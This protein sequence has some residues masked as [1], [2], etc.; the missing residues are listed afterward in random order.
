MRS[1]RLR[2]SSP[3]CIFYLTP[4]MTLYDRQSRVLWKRVR[5]SQWLV[6]GL[7]EKIL[8][9]F[10]YQSGSSLSFVVFD[11]FGW[12][13]ANPLGLKPKSSASESSTCTSGPWTQRGPCLEMIRR[14]SGRLGLGISI[15]WSW[16]ILLSVRVRSV[17]ILSLSHLAEFQVLC[18]SVGVFGSSCTQVMTLGTRQRLDIVYTCLYSSSLV[19]N[20]FIPGADQLQICW[21]LGRSRFLAG[22]R[23]G[24][25]WEGVE[26]KRRMLIFCFPWVLPVISS[27]SGSPEFEFSDLWSFV[28]W[29]FLTLSFYHSQLTS[30]LQNE[31]NR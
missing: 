8:L 20:I 6:E 24:L 17:R 4:D 7:V 9:V 12:N 23:G 29:G 25:S 16:L 14:M 11:F 15:I 19:S 21:G 3:R 31:T 28:V 30:T 22:C 13:E 2:C 27:K 10:S 5:A 1:I 26:A 18:L